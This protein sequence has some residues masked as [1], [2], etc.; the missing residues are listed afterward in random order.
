MPA[1]QKNVFKAIVWPGPSAILTDPFKFPSP[2]RPRIHLL[3]YSTLTLENL[4]SNIIRLISINLDTFKLSGQKVGSMSMP[5]K[6]DQ[7]IQLKNCG[8]HMK[9]DK[10]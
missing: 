8:Q 9:S 1:R 10:E 4:P 7:I 6:E 2:N 5:S 3:S